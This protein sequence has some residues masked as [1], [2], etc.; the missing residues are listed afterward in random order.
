MYCTSVMATLNSW[1]PTKIIWPS[2]Q[3]EVLFVS[4]RK[5]VLRGEN[6]A[7]RQDDI[8]KPSGLHNTLLK[9]LNSSDINIFLYVNSQ[10]FCIREAI[11]ILE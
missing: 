1:T 4:L 8:H 7:N 3:Q 11:R 6:W 2:K 5:G 10:V 9:M